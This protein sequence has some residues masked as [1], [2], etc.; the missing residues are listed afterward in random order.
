MNALNSAH[1]L[2]MS[3][4]GKDTPAA[5]RD[6]M[7]SYFFVSGILCEALKLIRAMNTVFAGDKS[8]ESNYALS[9][10]TPPVKR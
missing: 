6:R 1:S 4:T 7:N 10:K 8:F 9:S 5:I 2:M 3:T